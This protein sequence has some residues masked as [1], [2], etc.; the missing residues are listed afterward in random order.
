MKL[1]P[2]PSDRLV[3]HF[4]TREKLV[5]LEL[6]QLYPCLPPAHQQ[7]NKDGSLPDSAACQA[8]LDEA[9]AEQRTANKRQLDALLDAPETWTRDSR[10]WQ[11]SLARGDLEWLL[12]ILNDIRIGS[13]VQLGSPEEPADAVTPDNVSHFWRMEASGAFQMFFLR[14]LEKGPPGSSE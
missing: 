2:S 5:L 7:I 4:S 12:Q 10:G 3:F 6:M 14:A 9:L 1:L 11:C 8:L 13:W